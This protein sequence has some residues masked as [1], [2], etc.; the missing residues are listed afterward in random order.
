MPF[1]REKFLPGSFAPIENL[2]V[3]LNFAHRREQP[4]ART[5]GGG[6]ILEDSEKALLLR[7]ELPKTS[8]GDDVLALVRSSVLRGLSVEFSAIKERMVSGVREISKAVL[9]AIGVVDSGAYRMSVV[10]ARGKYLHR[11]KHL[12]L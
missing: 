2:D 10:E 5:K 8:I 11:K 4:I 3:I 7:A 12:W 1:G 9:H 6:L